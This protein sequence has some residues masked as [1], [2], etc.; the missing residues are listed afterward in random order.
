M[1][2]KKVTL[3]IDS[4][5]YSDFQKFCDERALMLSRLIEINMK[6]IME[7]KGK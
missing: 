2:K 1:A 3:S 5:V 6:K 7:E 4:K